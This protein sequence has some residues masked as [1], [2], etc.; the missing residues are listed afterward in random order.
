MLRVNLLPWRERAFEKRYRFWRGLLLCGIAG[1]ALWL[2]FSAWSTQRQ[3]ASR[4]QQLSALMAYQLSLQRQLESV[5]ALGER[6]RLAEALNQQSDAHF[7][8]SLH[9]V[10]RLRHLSRVVPEGV[11]ATRLSDSAVQFRLDGEGVAYG[12]ILALSKS[13]RDA[14]QLPQVQL[15]EVR[16]LPAANLSFSV[17]ARLPGGDSVARGD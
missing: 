9:V 12:E 16:L 6:Y 14:P 3:T 17:N 15:Q 5:Q 1:C 4:Q 8:R 2:I 7:Q 13:L 10:Q 11:W